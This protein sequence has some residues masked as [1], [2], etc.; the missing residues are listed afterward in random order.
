MFIIYF[1]GIVC[2]S[3]GYVHKSRLRDES[4]DPL[5]LE[6][7][8]FL[9]QAALGMGVETRFPLLAHVLINT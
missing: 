3:A 9:L 6:L 2:A 8:A 7:Q 4:M 1:S 5:E